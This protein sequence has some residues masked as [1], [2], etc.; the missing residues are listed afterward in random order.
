MELWVDLGL[1]NERIPKH[2][3]CLVSPAPLAEGARNRPALGPGGIPAAMAPLFTAR[4]QLLLLQ[5]MGFLIGLI[6]QVARAFGGP[7]FGS[8]TTPPV[9][10]PLLLLSGVQLAKLIRQ[11]KVSGRRALIPAGPGRPGFSGQLHP[12]ACGGG[13][14]CGNELGFCGD[15]FPFH[16]PWGGGG[17]ALIGDERRLLGVVVFLPRAFAVGVGRALL[18]PLHVSSCPFALFVCN[19]CAGISRVR[20]TKRSEGKSIPS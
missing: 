1:T 15:T 2:F 16:S 5:A 12:W 9:T 3:P 6:G 14:C 20:F 11:R 19:N 18:A 10:E 17:E 8:M 13:G 7:K 4:L